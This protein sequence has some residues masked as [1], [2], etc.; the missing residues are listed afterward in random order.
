MKLG[1]AFLN[2]STEYEKVES[3][4]PVSSADPEM[5]PSPKVKIELVLPRDVNTQLEDIALNLKSKLTDQGYLIGD[6][7][8]VSMEGSF[9]DPNQTLGLASNGKLT[10]EQNLMVNGVYLPDTWTPPTK[11]AI[12]TPED[13][14]PQG[15]DIVYLDKSKDDGDIDYWNIEN[16]LSTEGMKVVSTVD[17]LLEMLKSYTT[18]TLL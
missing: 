17:N 11:I 18:H 9:H 15:V 3:R 2:Y 14:I 1:K 7:K 6:S 4:I 16:Y 12:I 10:P 13:I 8:E 5:K